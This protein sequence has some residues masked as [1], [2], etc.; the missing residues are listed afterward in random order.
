[1]SKALTKSNR[2]A[3]VL[4]LYKDADGEAKYTKSTAKY[5]EKHPEL[6]S[7]LPHIIGSKFEKGA[8]R[9]V[10]DQKDYDVVCLTNIGKDSA[11]MLILLLLYFFS[12]NNTKYI[13][14]HTS[15]TVL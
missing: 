6:A 4:G 7:Q 11:G 12:Y 8:V 5:L 9:I 3:L 13:P 2:T 1:M 10:Y 14:L 15:S